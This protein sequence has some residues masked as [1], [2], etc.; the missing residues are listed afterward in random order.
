MK[1]TLRA[2]I[3]F[4]LSAGIF[5]PLLELLGWRNGHGANGI[6]GDPQ[7]LSEV[8]WDGPLVAAVTFAVLFGLKALHRLF[9]GDGNP[10]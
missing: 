3:G 4:S 6:W 9:G 1:M 8:W 2:A 10:G 5:V 7:P